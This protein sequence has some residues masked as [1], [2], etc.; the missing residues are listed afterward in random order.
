MVVAVAMTSELLWPQRGSRAVRSSSAV[1]WGASGL[2]SGQ[3][4]KTVSCSGSRKT[5]GKER[6]LRGCLGPPASLGFCGT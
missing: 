1:I 5:V 6:G 2:E 3:W 4:K